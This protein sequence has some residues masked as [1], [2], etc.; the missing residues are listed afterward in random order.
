MGVCLTVRAGGAGWAGVF[1]DGTGG[2]GG[3]GVTVCGICGGPWTKDEAGVVDGAEGAGE[4][5]GAD[6]MGAGDG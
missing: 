5:M 3:T 6:A 2:A 1:G 4:A